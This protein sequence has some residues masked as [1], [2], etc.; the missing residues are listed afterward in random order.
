MESIF[1]RI[2]LALLLRRTGADDRSAGLP[3]AVASRPNDWAKMAGQYLTGRMDE[4][5]FLMQA[6]GGSSEE[7]RKHECDAYYYVA[8]NHLL[9]QQPVI[10][11]EFFQKSI[12]TGMKKE[13]EYHLAEAEFARLR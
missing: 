4:S 12:E 7:T 13:V 8:M 2:Q 11:R 1:A 9:A 5:E 10:A 3:E 6:K